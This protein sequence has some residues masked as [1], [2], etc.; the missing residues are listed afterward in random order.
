[1]NRLQTFKIINHA[2]LSRVDFK[3]LI[4]LYQ[5]LLGVS[6]YSVYQL[7]FEL[8][9]ADKLDKYTY[10]FILDVLN[11][12]IEELKES[13]KKLEALALVD[14]FKKG[15]NVVYV[16]EQPMTPK[17]FISDTI[18][19]S[20]LKSE[21]GENHFELLVKMFETYRFEDESYERTTHLFDDVYETKRLET[22]NIT[23]P[24]EGR[25]NGSNI[26]IDSNFNLQAFIDN[27]PDRNKTPKLM[28]PK[29]QEEIMKI[30]YIYNLT[31]E[32][33]I[34]IY[35]ESFKR[36]APT[37]KELLNRATFQL[38]KET[39]KV[40]KKVENDEDLLIYQLTP[41]EIIYQMSKE[42]YI[43][44]ALH[45]IAELLVLKDVEE[46]LL[47]VLLV[48]VLEKKDGIMPHVNYLRTILNNWEKEGITDAKMAW[49]H[50]STYEKKKPTKNFKQGYSRTKPDAESPD[51]LDDYIEEMREKFEEGIGEKVWP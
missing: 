16:I 12:K 36:S 23:T 38:K 21:I 4:L 7:F 3:T 44:D 46:A 17:Q 51:W 47:N 20:Y 25:I 27:L 11:I 42:E 19:G 26:K 33:M 9:R 49:D 37:I 28:T 35:I 50:I 6:A 48:L 32:E 13:L 1:M 18:L 43:P 31:V 24:L 45:T 29:Y 40:T 34:E 39:I 8:S 2:N 5:P 30:A 41:R 22:I 14:T 15:D 10:Q